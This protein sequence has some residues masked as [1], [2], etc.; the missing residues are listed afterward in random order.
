[1]TTV[2]LKKQSRSDAL[3]TAFWCGIP[4]HV[5][6]QRFFISRTTVVERREVHN[7]IC[8]FDRCLFYD[9]LSERWEI[10]DPI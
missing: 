7:F 6:D 8:L 3:I 9:P 4:M 10:K 2:G 5:Q 1:M